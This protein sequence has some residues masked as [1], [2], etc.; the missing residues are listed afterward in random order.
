MKYNLLDKSKM[1]NIKDTCWYRKNKDDIESLIND[2]MKN[3]DEISIPKS[4]GYEFYVFEE[5]L[6]EALL[7]H[8]YDSSY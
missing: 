6:R 3:V 8:V 5:N 7:T 4:F 2:I 1:N